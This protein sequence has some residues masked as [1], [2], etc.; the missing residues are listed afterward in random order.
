MQI[1]LTQRRL[2]SGSFQAW[3][4][5]WQP[6]KFPDG[7]KK[8]YILRNVDDPDDVIAFGMFERPLSE[9]LADP[10]T[11]ETQQERLAALAEHVVSTGADGVYEIVEEVLPD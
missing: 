5:A 7:F 8:A 2:K 11:H 10:E 1:M 3:R 6:K 4:K 9:A